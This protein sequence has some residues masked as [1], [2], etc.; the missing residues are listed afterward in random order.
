MDG[1]VHSVGGGSYQIVLF[2]E[3]DPV[4]AYLRGRL[5]LENRLGEQVVIG[6]RVRTIQTSDGSYVIEEV[7]PRENAVVRS[8]GNGTQF[9]VLAVNVDRVLLVVAAM[10]PQPQRDFI[11]RM[12]VLAEAEDIEPVVVINKVDLKG[13]EDEGEILHDIYRS[14][15]YDVIRTSTVTKEGIDQLSLLIEKGITA[16][17][18]QSGVGKSSLINCLDPQM[19]LKTSE[20]SAKRGTGRHTTV[21]ARLLPFSNGGLLADTPGFSDAGVKGL[22]SQDVLA[23]LFPEFLA[24]L[25]GCQFRRCSH[26]H[27]PDCSVKEA[28]SRGAIYPSRFESYQMLYEE[29]QES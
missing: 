20:V 5:K 21:R 16:F 11:D 14:V 8:R 15:G 27:E 2:P 1:V 26:L 6:D 29:L 24:H 17:A 23:S 28:L 9:K 13:A 18:G 25:S 4:E 22:L 19:S 3:G 7:L 12:L 10:R